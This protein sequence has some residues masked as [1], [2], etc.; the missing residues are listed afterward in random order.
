MVRAAN[1]GNREQ[2]ELMTNQVY[3]FCH[4]VNL[5]QGEGMYAYCMFWGI[6]K[7]FN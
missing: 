2:R 4:V 1:P 3:A 5:Q 7:S 6:K